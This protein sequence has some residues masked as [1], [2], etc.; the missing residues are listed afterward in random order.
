ELLAKP[1]RRLHRQLA[2]VAAAPTDEQWHDLRIRVKRVRYAA[3]LAGRLAGRRRRAELDTLVGQTKAV[4]E[5]LGA[6]N[7]TV[8]AEHH[9]RQLDDLSPAGWLA[10]GRLVE[11]QAARRDAL[12]D[13]LPAACGQLYSLTSA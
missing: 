10:L 13:R 8:V 5:A 6:F 2:V 1:L 12:R 11:R 3:E 4:Q 9:L 7:D